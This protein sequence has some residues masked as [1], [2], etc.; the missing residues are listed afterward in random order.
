MLFRSEGD[1]VIYHEASLFFPL[2]DGS[3]I[4]YKLF[5]KSNPP[6]SLG[7]ITETAIAKKSKII[8]LAIKNWL[9]KV[10]RFKV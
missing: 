3:A 10:Q 2:P 7:N 5:G 8:S 1:N 6:E 9:S 4:L